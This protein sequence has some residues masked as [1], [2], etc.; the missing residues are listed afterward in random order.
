MP[1]SAR[2]QQRAA[3]QIVGFVFGMAQHA[4]PQRHA[5]RAAVRE[6]ALQLFGRRFAIGLVGRI[7]PVAEAGIQG[8]IECDHDMLRP[9][10][11]QD[12]QQE[13]R[14]ALYGIGGPA[15]GIPEL[16]GHG[17]PG[18]EHVDAGVDQIQRRR[19]GARFD[20]KVAVEDVV[21]V[22]PVAVNVHPGVQSVSIAAGSGRSRS[23]PSICAVPIWMKPATVSS[24]PMPSASR[25]SGS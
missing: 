15:V 9:L 10:A 7:Q 4:Q 13:T 20:R 12:V 18:A 16:V 14:E 19:L 5:Q 23:G 1:G 22:V 21:D 17:V 6:L 8:F 11:F 2:L 25:I 3:D 24:A